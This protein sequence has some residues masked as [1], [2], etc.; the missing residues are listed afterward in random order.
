MNDLDSKTSNPQLSVLIIRERQHV[1][2]ISGGREKLIPSR[3]LYGVIPDALLEAYRFW[4]DESIAPRGTKSED[5]SRFSLGYKRMLGYPLEE[6]GEYM[7]IVEFQYTG[8]WTDFHTP[9]TLNQNSPFILQSTRFPGRTVRIT[10]RLK[11]TMMESFQMRTRIAS[12]LDSSKLLA[13]P[14]KKKRTDKV[15]ADKEEALFKIDE[16]V[17]CNFEGIFLLIYIY[18]DR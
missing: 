8:S 5:I 2:N 13:S 3:L 4:E 6:D 9:V 12:I 14:L 15:A 10:R 17:E 1:L 16:L 11:S 7:I 18:I